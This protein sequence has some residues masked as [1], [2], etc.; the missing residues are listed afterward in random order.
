MLENSIFSCY[1]QDL[2]PIGLDGSNLVNNNVNTVSLARTYWGI[3]SSSFE[4]PP[5]PVRPAASGVQDGIAPNLSGLRRYSPIRP[6]QTHS[7]TPLEFLRSFAITL[8]RN[9]YFLLFQ[10]I[11]TIAETLYYIAPC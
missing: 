5:S 2:I 9:I 4:I 7:I 3:P 10:K 11:E 6:R 8:I 1:C